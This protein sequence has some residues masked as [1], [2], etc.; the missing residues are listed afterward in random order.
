MK[1]TVVG[2]T[3]Q[4]GSRVVELLTAAGNDVVAASRASGADVLTGEG[5]GA[6][7][8]GADVL[9]DVVNSP[10]FDDDPV[11]V[12]TAGVVTG[13]TAGIG[14]VRV[15]SVAPGPTATE[16][17]LA[18]WGSVNDE[19]GRALPLGR[20]ADA[21]EIAEAVLFL[22]AP[23]SSFSTGSTPTANPVH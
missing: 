22:A 15:N 23:R 6:A 7:L 10:S 12:W 8:N 20:T 13:G 3:G 1:I 18:E 17:V 2:A 21:R 5:L 4:V 19:L 11:L 14:L 16:G 9:V